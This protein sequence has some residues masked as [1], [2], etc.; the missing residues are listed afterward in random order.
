MSVVLLTFDYAK[1]AKRSNVA[2][3][4]AY[5]FRWI[6]AKGILLKMV[7]LV[8]FFNNSAHTP[9]IHRSFDQNSK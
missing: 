8:G 9:R 7:I 6:E 5:L 2:N 4:W 3:L 1:V